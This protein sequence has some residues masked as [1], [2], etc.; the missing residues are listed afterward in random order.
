MAATPIK[1]TLITTKSR[2]D[3]YV[4]GDKDFCRVVYVPDKVIEKNLTDFNGITV[5]IRYSH[6]IRASF[7]R[8]PAKSGW[9]LYLPAFSASEGYFYFDSEDILKSILSSVIRLGCKIVFDYTV[10]LALYSRIAS[11]FPMNIDPDIRQ[12]IRMSN[13][14]ETG[15]TELDP[16][17]KKH[18]LARGHADFNWV[19]LVG[20]SYS[21]SASGSGWPIVWKEHY[22]PGGL[23]MRRVSAFR[24]KHFVIHY[25]YG[26]DVTGKYRYPGYILLDK[27]TRSARFFVGSLDALIQ[28]FILF[29]RAGVGF[30]STSSVPESTVRQ[31]KLLCEEHKVPSL[32]Q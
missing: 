2:F 28:L 23:S 21:Q 32:Q 14:H 22:S 8:G 19:F 13:K 7:E 31:L 25:S 24:G 26:E 29:L 9:I 18:E 20:V 4:P 16:P 1:V 6:N 27:E 12:G 15:K 11:V 10:S 5:D 17:E 30:D 3:P